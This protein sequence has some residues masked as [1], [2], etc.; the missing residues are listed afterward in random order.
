[1]LL[2]IEKK[3][4][5]LKNTD[6]YWEIDSKNIHSRLKNCTYRVVQQTPGNPGA[7]PYPPKYSFG[8]NVAYKHYLFVSSSTVAQQFVFPGWCAFGWFIGNLC[9]I[10]QRYVLYCPRPPL[11][12]KN[13]HWSTHQLAMELLLKK[14]SVFLDVSNLLAVIPR[15]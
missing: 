4:L 3:Q 6:L 7:L 15:M 2:N 5:I 11:H 12:I 1:M 8:L 10:L 9:W 14:S 13:S